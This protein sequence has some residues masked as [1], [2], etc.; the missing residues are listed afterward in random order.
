MSV[1]SSVLSFYQ[2]FKYMHIKVPTTMGGGGGGGDLG[3]STVGRGGGGYARFYCTFN[4]IFASTFVIFSTRISVL[5]V[6]E[7]FVLCTCMWI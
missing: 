1:S 3:D 5:F 2:P 4:C 7:W 6:C